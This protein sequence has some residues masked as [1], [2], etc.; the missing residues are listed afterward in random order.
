MESVK[1][2][3]VS[4]ARNQKP[5]IDPHYPAAVQRAKETAQRLRREGIIDAEG[6]RIRTDLP[7]DMRDGQDRD[8]GG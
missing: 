3:P 6:H 2:M 5:K 7:V 8:Y 4:K 1:T